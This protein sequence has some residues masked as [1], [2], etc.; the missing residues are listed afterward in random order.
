MTC[1]SPIASDA[2]P[3][4]VVQTDWQTAFEELVPAIRSQARVAL[5]YLSCEAQQEA[6]QEVTCTACVF[7]ARLHQHGRAEVA[8]ASTLAWFAVKRY[9][10]GRR[11]VERTSFA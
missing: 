5:R 6:L 7:F 8:T 9:R 3:A 10:V 1:F 11:V 2:V 4:A